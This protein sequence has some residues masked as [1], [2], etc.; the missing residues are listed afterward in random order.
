MAAGRLGK[1]RRWAERN[2]VVG[3]GP[4]TG[5]PYRITGTPWAEVMDTVDDPDVQQVVVRGAV[6]SGKTALTIA[7]GLG[8]LAAGR[9]VLVYEPDDKLKRALAA[10]IVTWG[11]LCRD[12]EVRE[13]YLPKRPPHRRV[14]AS[15]G[16][17]EVISAREG[18]AGVFRTAEVVLIDELRLFPRDLLGDLIDR[19]ASFGSKG[20]IMTVSSAGFE[21]ECKTS[22]ELE[23]SDK[24]HWFMKCA[25]CG[26]ESSP[27]WSNVVYAKRRYPIYSMACCG[28]A[29]EGI[30][31]RRAIEAGRWKPTKQAM[32]EGIVGFHADAFLSKFETLRTI[33]RQWQRASAHRKQTSS[34]SEI[35]SFQTGR[36][37]VPYRPQDSG[38]VTPEAIRTSCR[39][40]YDPAVVPAEASVLIACVDTQD[41]RLEAEVTGWG[42]HEVA[43]DDATKIKGWHHHEFRGLRH[44]GRWYRLRRWGLAYKRFYGDPGNV[45]LWNELAQWVETPRPHATGPLLRP[46]TCAVD[47]GGHYG[48]MVSE[49][50]KDRGAGYQALKGLPP[51]RFGAVLARRSVT[52]DVLTTY[53]ENGLLLV[54]GNSGKSSIF[55]MLRQSIAGVEPRP[56]VWPMDESNYSIVEFESI[57]SEHLVRHLDKRTGA[58]RLGW[59]KFMKHN[60]G[61]DLAYYSLAVASHL[62]IGFL[63]SEARAIEA[64]AERKLAA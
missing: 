17:L 29:L 30:P 24:R 25:N 40:P 36:L 51:Q 12:E 6:Q 62:G 42:V 61:L 16:S 32:V 48:A 15:G 19:T 34:M 18:T 5:R 1:L 55:S 64:A 58:T 4:R 11:R 23:K 26:Q 56:C 31:F 35:I 39:E 44:E 14:T 43:E 37:C 7:A 13:A 41:D 33:T 63:L 52:E 54:C 60:E 28:T 9:S 46:V 45:D 53:G 20:R 21:H 2:I 10:R 8:H 50:V 3:D 49:F 22:T 38:G 47:S 59:R 27:V 57:V